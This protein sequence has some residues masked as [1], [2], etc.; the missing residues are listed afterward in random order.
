MTSIHESNF[1]KLSRVLPK[2]RQIPIGEPIKL[3]TGRFDLTICV[4]EN[5]KY[6]SQVSFKS[7]LG[8]GSFC[9]PSMHLQ[10]RIYHDAR[11]AEVI[12][13]QHNRRFDSRYKYPNTKMHQTN[14]KQ[15][16]NYFLSEWLDFCLIQGYV[17]YSTEI[18]VKL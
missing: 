7:T 18:G 11:V 1:S 3:P 15:Q 16:I 12:D 17:L 5:T 10:V 6:T 8:S 14:E 9:I 4:D 2:I 13:Y